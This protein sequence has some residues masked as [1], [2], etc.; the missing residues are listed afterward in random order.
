MKQ[1][2]KKHID[3]QIPEF[4]GETALQRMYLYLE[5]KVLAAVVLYQQ[6]HNTKFPNKIE[7]CLADLRHAI[8]IKEHIEDYEEVIAYNRVEED[9]LNIMKVVATEFTKIEDLM[10][11]DA[12]TLKLC[13][14]GF[15]HGGLEFTDKALIFQPTSTVK[16]SLNVTPSWAS[17]FKSCVTGKTE[18]L[19]HFEKSLDK[20]YIEEFSENHNRITT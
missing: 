11:F 2:K 20:E 19:E 9:D 15:T 12:E 18:T 10:N 5:A 17:F 16:K 1:S 3:Y 6:M 4:T 14:I 8:Y 13:K 7:N